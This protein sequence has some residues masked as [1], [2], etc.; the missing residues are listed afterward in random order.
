MILAFATSAV[1]HLAANPSPLELRIFHALNFDGGPALDA[2]ARALS[3]RAFGFA[4]GA[5][6][7]VVALRRFR[8][9]AAAAGLGGAIFVSDFVGSHLLRPAFARRRPCYAL[10]PDAV[11]WIG[12]AADVGCFPSLHAANFFAMAVVAWTVDRRLGIAAVAVAIAVALSRVYLGVHWPGDI[13]GGA[14]WGAMA[15][16]LGAAVLRRGSR[17]ARALG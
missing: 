1:T 17:W 10:P 12:H 3:A 13:L 8:F 9:L 11:R 2:L 16:S 15:G 7:L 4:V 14:V 6:V 5:V